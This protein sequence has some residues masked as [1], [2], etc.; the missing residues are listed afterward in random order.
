MAESER[1]ESGSKRRLVVLWMGTVMA[2]L[3]LTGRLF[4]W[5]VIRHKDLQDV[6]EQWQLLDRSI[7]AL[8]GMITDRNGF[9]LALDEYEFEVFASPRDIQEPVELAAELA[10]VLGMNEDGLA[11]L[12]AEGEE[13]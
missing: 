10:P 1:H 4:Y 6:G 7:P 12:L 8:R 2:V 13:A 9:I 11:E 5:Q 3:I